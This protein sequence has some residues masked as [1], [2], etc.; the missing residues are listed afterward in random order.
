MIFF[1]LLNIFSVFT[2]LV[3]TLSATQTQ[4]GADNI[5]H[6]SK[7]IC[8]WVK[9]NTWL[10]RGNWFLLSAAMSPCFVFVMITERSSF[11]NNVFPSA[12]T[13]IIE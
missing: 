10:I 5:N 13:R 6:I 9:C 2:V 1:G 7:F 12:A 3:C 11:V 4:P 8:F